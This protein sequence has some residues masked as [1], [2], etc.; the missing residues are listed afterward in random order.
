MR[1]NNHDLSDASFKRITL[2]P[3]SEFNNC[4]MHNVDFK[5]NYCFDKLKM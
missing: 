4:R 5:I 1:D 3:D 2:A